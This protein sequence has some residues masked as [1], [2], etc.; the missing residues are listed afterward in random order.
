MKN[1]KRLIAFDIEANGNITNFQR[2][3]ISKIPMLSIDEIK[4]MWCKKI[5]K[6]KIGITDMVIVDYID[7][8]KK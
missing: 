3:L 7:I 5:E 6:E 1:K 8:L 2:G 4:E